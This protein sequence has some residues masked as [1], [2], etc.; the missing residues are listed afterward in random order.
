[1]RLLSEAL[2]LFVVLVLALWCQM[3]TKPYT[4]AD[5]PMPGDER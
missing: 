3:T 2:A 4:A 5:G 1:M